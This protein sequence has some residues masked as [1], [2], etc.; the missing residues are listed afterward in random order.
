MKIST[1]LLHTLFL[2]FFIPGLQGQPVLET[3]AQKPMPPE[4]IDKD[5]G[6]RLV[7]ITRREGPNRSFYFHNVPF[8]KAPDGKWIIFRANFE[9]E[10]QVYAVEIQKHN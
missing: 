6:H 3:G 5:T 8:V 1:I 7:R 4:W 10:S 9:G 2:L